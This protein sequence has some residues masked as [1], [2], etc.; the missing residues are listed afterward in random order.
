MSFSRGSG[1]VK[2]CAA[3]CLICTAFSGSLLAQRPDP[4]QPDIAPD[5]VGKVDD[6][7]QKQVSGE[8]LQKAETE[9]QGVLAQRPDYYRALFNLGLI[10][11][12]QGKTDQALQM[13]NKAKNVRD[14]YNIADDSILN[15]IGWTYMEAGN[16]SQAESTFLDALNHQT[17]S[18]PVSAE[19]L[20]NNLGYL[21]LQKGETDKAR[22]YLT[23]SVDQYHSKGATK[24]LKMVDEYDQKQKSVPEKT[25]AASTQTPT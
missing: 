17:A 6:A 1:R 10:Y 3:F 21:Y 4:F 19:R 2:F 25:S 15:S 23:K 8:D 14:Q 13:L 5:L 18:N 9:L 16:L 12:S 11:Q 24:I 22:F 20:L 7:K